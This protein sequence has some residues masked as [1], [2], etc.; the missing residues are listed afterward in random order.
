MSVNY[1]QAA[2]EDLCKMHVAGD[3]SA[4]EELYNRYFQYCMGYIIKKGVSYLDAEECV[5]KAFSHSVTRIKNIREFKYFKTWIGRACWNAYLDFY[6]SKTRRKIE[7]I[8][9]TEEDG[10]VG[11][12][13]RPVAELR[14]KSLN[15]SERLCQDDELEVKVNIANKA[16]KKL[17]SKFREVLETCIIKENSYE[18]T[19]KILNIP[20]GTVMSR[21][22]YG[23]RKFIDLYKYEMNKYKASKYKNGKG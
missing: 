16:F 23:R 17:S 15:P 19:S 5:Q 18:N 7:T 22:Y 3:H 12:I 8:F 13:I 2:D 21:M 14:E 20:H 11:K 10:R 4:F 9:S 6:R 1:K